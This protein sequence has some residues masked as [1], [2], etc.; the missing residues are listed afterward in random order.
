MQNT[1][2][3]L[4]NE[5]AKTHGDYPVVAAIAQQLKETLRQTPGWQNL[6]DVQR[7]TLDMECSK[8]ARIL[9]G[10]PN[11]PDHWDDKAGYNRL[12]SLTLQTITS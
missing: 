2:D 5:R 8:N 3:T 10:N 1:I 11:E 4:L 6:S 12:V 7:E 9:S